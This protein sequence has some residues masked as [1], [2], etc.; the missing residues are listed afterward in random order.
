MRLYE[1]SC[2]ELE[3]GREFRYGRDIGVYL[4]QVYET[5]KKECTWLEKNMLDNSWHYAI[6]QFNGD[7]E[8]VREENDTNRF[9]VCDCS[10]AD[11]FIKSLICAYQQAAL[12]ANPA[13][14]EYAVPF[15]KVEL[16]GWFLERFGFSKLQARDF[17]MDIQAGNRSAGGGREFFITSYC[18]EAESYGEFLDRYLEIVPGERFGL[19]K[20]DLLPKEELKQFLGYR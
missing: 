14:A 4:E 19:Y 2:S 8:F 7:W 13:A 9:S 18:F 10:T 16:N 17:K 3:P 20:E 11:N 15:G 12:L 6:K 5:A 1:R